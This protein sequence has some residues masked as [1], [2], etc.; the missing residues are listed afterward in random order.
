ME[1]YRSEKITD[2]T[3]VITNINDVKIWLVEGT[4]EALLID[5]GTGAGDL[6]KYVGT[7]TDKPVNTVLLTHGHCD[8][9]GGAYGFSRVFL[10]PED[11]ELVREHAGFEMRKDYIRMIM[12]REYDEEAERQIMPD[13]TGAYLPLEHEM[14][15]DLGNFT[16]RALHLPGHTQGMMCILNCE[17][18]WILTG[19]ACNTFTFMFDEYTCS[20]AEYME[21]LIG[22]R[23]KYADL[24]DTVFLSH[25]PYS[26]SP[27]VIDENIEVCDEILAGTDDK[28]PF[29]FMGREGLYVAKTVVNHVR[30]DGKDG[31]IVYSS[32]HIR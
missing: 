11:S 27:S 14:T 7:L 20:V 4:E 1:F 5:T 19:D 23:R 28:V 29:S 18:R 16:L 25:G 32:T 10:H 30:P 15:F 8:H 9:A 17:E 21:N 13:H 12:G 6:K 3:T 2:S 26:V 31:N 22:F 24:F